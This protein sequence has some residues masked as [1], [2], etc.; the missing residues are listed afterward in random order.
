M[1]TFGNLPTICGEKSCLIYSPWSRS[2]IR[3]TRSELEGINLKQFLRNNGFLKPTEMEKEES[4]QIAR[5]GFFVTSRCNLNC[6]YCYVQK[7]QLSEDLDIGLASKVVDYFLS[8]N[9]DRFYLSFTGGEPSL[10]MDLIRQ[11]VNQVEHSNCQP[12]FHISTNGLL[13]EDQI[14][15][16]LQHHFSISVSMDSIPEIHDTL[17]FSAEGQKT[18]SEVEDTLKVLAEREA[19]FQVRATLQGEGVFAFP[20][21][22]DYWHSLGVKFVHFE[23]AFD[24]DLKDGIDAEIYARSILLAIKRAQRH[25]VWLISSAFQNLIRPSHYFCTST[26]GGKLILLPDGTFTACYRSQSKNSPFAVGEFDEGKG[27][28]TFDNARLSYLEGL[29]VDSKAVCH[30]CPVKYICGGGCPYRDMYENAEEANEYCRLKRLLIRDAILHLY[31]C[32]KKVEAAVVLGSQRYA[33]LWDQRI[34]TGG[35]HV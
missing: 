20:K 16:L 24:F 14:H 33:D 7:T 25:G 2:F 13:D 6:R 26:H 4:S 32:S 34:K 19:L 23:K 27:K 11:L 28:V 18:A 31:E 12:A 21:A 35:K 1:T 8:K 9:P 22:I 17:R 15:F 10:R 5:L 29:S 30:D 3:V